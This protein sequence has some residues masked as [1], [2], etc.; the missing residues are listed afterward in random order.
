MYI[1]IHTLLHTYTFI[2]HTHTWT[3]KYDKIMQYRLN[4]IDKTV[5]H[6]NTLINIHILTHSY[7]NVYIHAH[8]HTLICY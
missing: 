1:H 8:T 6:T 3:Q 5:I 4:H 7:T 2:V